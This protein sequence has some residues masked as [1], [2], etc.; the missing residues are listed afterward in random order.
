MKYAS[1]GL[2]SAKPPT[3]RM[4]YRNLAVLPALPSPPSLSRALWGPRIP[5]EKVEIARKPKTEKT[6]LKRKKKNRQ[7][8][9]QDNT[10]RRCKSRRK[11]TKTIKQERKP[12]KNGGREKRH[13]ETE[14]RQEKTRFQRE[15]QGAIAGEPNRAENVAGEANSNAELE[16]ARNCAD[17]VLETTLR[18]HIRPYGY[19]IYNLGRTR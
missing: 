11:H 13:R 18:S 6:K 5:E 2:F 17:V 4:R 14:G 9:E 7:K 1:S 15:T 8:R 12:K 10:T 3:R 16:A 19:K